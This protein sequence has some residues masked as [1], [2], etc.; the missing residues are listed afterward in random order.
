M[1]CRWLLI[2]RNWISESPE[3]KLG[4]PQFI[5]EKQS[6]RGGKNLD[7]RSFVPNNG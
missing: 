4:V 3:V 7:V 1:L 6:F 5:K 2:G